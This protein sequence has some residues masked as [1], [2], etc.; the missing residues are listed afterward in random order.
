MSQLMTA[1]G[2]DEDDDDGIYYPE[3]DG[4]ILGES[5]RQINCVIDL[6]NAFQALFFN[7][8]D[9]FIAT[10]LLWYPVKGKQIICTSPDVMIAFGRPPGDR[11]SYQQWKEGGIPFQ[12]VFEIT[13]PSNNPPEMAKK[14]DFYERYGVEEY[15]IYD[16]DENSFEGWIRKGSKLV[17]IKKLHTHV[18]A[19]AHSSSPLN[20]PLPTKN[21]P[22]NHRGF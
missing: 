17:P 7:R 19:S 20:N 10:I 6:F 8:N 9:V 14:F 2:Y 5:T 3:S 22:Q 15:Y 12:I 13:S 1:S 21:T 16:P 11:S 4:E 18:R